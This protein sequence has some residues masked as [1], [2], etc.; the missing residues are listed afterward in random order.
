M[1]ERNKNPL[2]EVSLSP[3]RLDL[4]SI[5]VFVV[6]LI[7]FLSPEERVS[8]LLPYQGRECR[9]RHAGGNDVTQDFTMLKRIL[10]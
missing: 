4:I 2:N 6:L 7:I 8:F 9:H 5:T 10:N 3:S 1:K